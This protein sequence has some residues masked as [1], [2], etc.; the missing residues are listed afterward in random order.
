MFMQEMGFFLSGIRISQFPMQ[1]SMEEHAVTIT[2]TNFVNV[3]DRNPSSI[4]T[5]PVNSCPDC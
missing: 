2:E 4:Y 1:I 3:S 5:K